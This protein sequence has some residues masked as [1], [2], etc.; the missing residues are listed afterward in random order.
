LGFIS[1]GLLVGVNLRLPLEVIAR[2][3]MCAL[4]DLPSLIL[5]TGKRPGPSGCEFPEI[6]LDGPH[7][8]L[9][10]R[11]CC[12]RL[13]LRGAISYSIEAASSFEAEAGTELSAGLWA[14]FRGLGRAPS[15]PTSVPGFLGYS[16]ERR[17]DTC[18]MNWCVPDELTG[19]LEV[20]VLGA[21]QWYTGF[22]KCAGRLR[23]V[24]RTPSVG[25]VSGESAGPEL[26]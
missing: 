14:E 12:V 5:A 3:A 13:L 8:R 6:A 2:H 9:D 25:T 1:G 18:R 19:Q 7:W 22:S 10:S 17:S 24:A 26:G 20:V 4:S 11:Q 23:R 21:S 16:A 15:D